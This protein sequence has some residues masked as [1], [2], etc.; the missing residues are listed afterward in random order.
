[1]KKIFLAS[2]SLIFAFSALGFTF[3]P[4]VEAQTIEEYLISNPV[5]ELEG[6]IVPTGIPGTNENLTGKRPIIKAQSIMSTII[7]YLLRLI[8]A[9]ALFG[10]LYNAFRLIIQSA[11]EQVQEKARSGLL[12]S[13][14]GL[15]IVLLAHALVT[16]LVQILSQAA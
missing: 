10:V 2:L 8:G 13:I 5:D 11:D 16:A 3:F 12:W 1:M 14:V 6:V 9:F 7:L 4:Q 15:V